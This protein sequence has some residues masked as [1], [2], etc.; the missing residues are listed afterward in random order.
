M[1]DLHNTSSLA[2]LEQ[3]L[4]GMIG[5]LNEVQIFLVN[6]RAVA[7]PL[8]V[9]DA[10]LSMQ[11]TLPQIQ[12]QV[13]SLEGEWRSLRSLAQIGQVV[14]S[15]LDLDKVLQIVMDT[16][17]QI[18]GAERGF[19]VLRNEEN[20][21][22]TTR[23]ARNWEQES[24]DP[25]EFAVSRTIIHRVINDGQ[26][27]LTTNAQ[28][29]PRFG[30]QQSVVAYNLRSILCVPL[31]LKN[32]RIGVV[33][34]DNR[35]RSGLFS[36]RHLELLAAFSNQA[37]VAIDNARL[38]ASVRRTLA[39]V[40]ELKNLMDNVF[41]SI[42]SGVL[43]TDVEEHIVL[44][45]RSAEQILGHMNQE[46][47][48]HS[49]QGMMEG[50]ASSLEPYMR[51]VLAENKSIVGLEM[52]PQLPVRGSVDL[53]L[54]LSP[55]KDGQQNTQGVTIVM[56]DLT[57]KKHLEA[58]RRLFERMVSPAVINH[59]DP[60]KVQLGGDRMEITTLF[61][62]IR[63]FTH[64]SET[65]PPEEL[66]KVL[67][68]Y[69]AVSAE[70]VLGEEGT[71]D[72]FLGDAIMALF[73]APIPQPDHTM[74]AVRAALAMRD[75]IYALHRE[76]PSE[77]HLHFGAGIHRGDAVLGLIGTEKRLD[78]T[79]IGDSVNT[80]KRIQENAGPGQIFISLPAY[81]QVAKYILAQPVEPILAKGKR[82][83]VQVYEVLGLS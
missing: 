5:L 16:I 64:F 25:N 33:Y 78:Y 19:I 43:T 4:S 37:A 3:Q 30:G 42:A 22:L 53:R 11:E 55:L 34:T 63:G 9:S 15:S 52:N 35:I 58:Q 41:F 6:N 70:A 8:R 74:R 61:A 17:I 76:L 72:K 44:C 81:E 7:T 75:A 12:R 20:G 68:R 79:A 66:V 36:Q 83:P 21:E 39:E 10:V 48:G 32:D 31:T 18:T 27:V 38:F 47:V 57:E 2:S 51:E 77:F 23:I 60:D 59:L 49:L 45:N 13:Q 69:L 62:D 67:N 14:N 56:E 40:T 1:P 50:F 65:L 46:L 24:L 26:P 82:E 71:I 28:E 73:N 29:D 54:S 80:A